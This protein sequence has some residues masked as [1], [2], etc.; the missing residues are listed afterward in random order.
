MSQEYLQPPLYSIPISME[1]IHNAT[2]AQD[3]DLSQAPHALPTELWLSILSNLQPTD[4]SLTLST[5]SGWRDLALSPSLWSNIQLRGRDLHGLARCLSYSDGTSTPL[6]LEIWPEDYRIDTAHI[7]K[8][9]QAVLFR[10]RT[11]ILHIGVPYADPRGVQCAL[12][13]L[14][15]SDAPILQTFVVRPAASAAL[16]G[17]F[18]ME[19]VQVQENLFA[20]HA[21]LL[22][23]VEL[24]GCSAELNMAPAL[25]RTTFLKLGPNV[26]NDVLGTRRDKSGE[27]DGNVV[28]GG[29]EDAIPA[30]VEQLEFWVQ[31]QIDDLLRGTWRLPS[32]EHLEKLREVTLYLRPNVS[33]TW[34][35]LWDT[36]QDQGYLGRTEAV[37]HIRCWD[38]NLALA[39]LDCNVWKD[40]GVDMLE[41]RMCVWL[42]HVQ[43]SAKIRISWEV[44]PGPEV[45]RRLSSTLIERAMTKKM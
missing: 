21:P 34:D 3:H 41:T 35:V 15:N 37:V 30:G 23:H 10:T 31:A 4:L 20:G 11:L 44:A 7:Y 33:M 19:L 32:V 36:L 29:S 16:C 13:A 24:D 25:T 22:K 1:G 40:A 18:A 39:A 28:H 42:V 8:L 12:V 27:Q 2:I 14:L 5:S 45:R 38:A 9:L 6:T 43:G 17:R 26:F